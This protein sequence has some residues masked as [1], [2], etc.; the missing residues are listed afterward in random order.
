[1]SKKSREKFASSEENQKAVDKKLFFKECVN[2]IVRGS[3]LG[4]ILSM[5]VLPTADSV[6]SVMNKTEYLSKGFV[7]P[8]DERTGDN[9]L[10]TA[11]FST[12]ELIKK[13][14]GFSISYYNIDDPVFLAWKNILGQLPQGTHVRLVT[15]SDTS[16]ILV[17]ALRK[18]Y[19]YLTISP[20]AVVEKSDLMPYLAYPRDAFFA[21]GRVDEKNKFVLLQSE[22]DTIMNKSMLDASASL[23]DE[24]G[25]T[26][27]IYTVIRGE[28]DKVLAIKSPDVFALKGVQPSCINGDL[29]AVRF[30]GGKSGLIL[31]RENLYASLIA[32]NLLKARTDKRLELSLRASIND[33]EMI[34]TLYKNTFA[35]DEV[36]LLGEEELIRKFDNQ[37]FLS[38]HEDIKRHE[39]FHSDMVVVVL[40]ILFFLEMCW[41]L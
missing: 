1:M 36:V 40:Q 10:M 25:Y 16:E 12:G 41:L 23:K 30:P 24:E 35:V 18:E 34:K 2:S 37:R 15:E 8:E 13:E 14:D 11:S 17:Q 27:V 5:A 20:Y 38:L 33:V 21:T 28:I 31:G 32:S 29:Q 3:M 19:P 6:R 22:T 39:V 26:S 7:I 9:I 4:M